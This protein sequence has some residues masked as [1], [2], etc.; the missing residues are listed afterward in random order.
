MIILK[1]TFSTGRAN[2]GMKKYEENHG[3]RKQN[4]IYH[5]DSYND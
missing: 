2:A 4:T 5:D 3:M 1:L